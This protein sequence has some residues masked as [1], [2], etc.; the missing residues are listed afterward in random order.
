MMPLSEH[1]ARK[2]QT[3]VDSITI[4]GLSDQI[5]A[6]VYVCESAASESS[7]SSVCQLLLPIEQRSGFD[8]CTVERAN[9]IWF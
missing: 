2:W 3:I 9:W 5:W 6:V 1:M 8:I 7:P 4:V